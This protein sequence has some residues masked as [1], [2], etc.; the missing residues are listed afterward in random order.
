MTDPREALVA[1]LGRPDHAP[2]STHDPRDGSCQSCP[3]PLHEM[4]PE[5][6]ADA[7]LDEFDVTPRG[8]GVTIQIGGSRAG[9][10]QAL[11]EQVA[12]AVMERGGSATVI[13]LPSVE[14]LT[15]AMHAEVCC[16]CDPTGCD[17]Q[18]VPEAR[19][20]RAVLAMLPG[21]TEAEVRQDERH[22]LIAALRAKFGAT[23]RAADYI[24]RLPEG[25]ADRG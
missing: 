5:D 25:W 10:T 4:P 14:D 15:R 17:V 8:E 9:K 22:R 1:L 24:E 16:P 13:S 7:I 11:A 2:M 3:W 23:N 6:I 19:Y 20:A 21:R 12:E 18:D